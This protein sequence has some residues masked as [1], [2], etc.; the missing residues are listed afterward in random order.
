[1]RRGTTIMIVFLLVLILSA[2]LAQF[3]LRLG[4]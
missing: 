4:P 3:V 2:A 1:M